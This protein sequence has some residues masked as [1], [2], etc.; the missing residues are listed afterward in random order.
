MSFFRSPL[1]ARA[2]F[3]ALLLTAAAVAPAHAQTDDDGIRLRLV[4]QPVWHD[5]KDDLD[6]VV[7][8]ENGSSV[9]LEGFSLQVRVFSLLTTRSDLE[10][11]L[12][13]DPSSL[14]SGLVPAEF[15]TTILPGRA[16]VVRLDQ[17][18][19]ALGALSADLGAGVYPLTVTL[20]DADGI[21]ALDSISTFL[22]FFPSEVDAPLQIVPV[23]AFAEVPAR[24]PAGAFEPHPSAGTWNLEAALG[25]R[26]WVP[27][28]LSALATKA[29]RGVRLGIAASPR[30]LEELADMANGYER[31]DD[32]GVSRVRESAGV[33]RT[34]GD[35]LDALGTLLRSGRAQPLLAP[36][37][38]PELPAIA[39]DLD[40]LQQQLSEGE[41]VL[42][43]ALDVTPGRG[44]IFPP[45]GRLD[46]SS[47]DDLH[48]LDAAASTFFSPESLE[49]P[50]ALDPSCPP[51]FVGATYTCPVKVTTFGGKSRGYV[52]DDRL[53]ERAVAMATGTGRIALQR[54]FAETAMIWAEQPAVE[55]R[56]VPLV[57]PASWHPPPRVANLFVRT[58]GRAPW[59]TTL[60]PRAGLHRG[61]G[62]GTRILE[63]PDRLSFLDH[64]PY[65]STLLGAEDALESFARIDPPVDM[66]EG[67]RRDLLVAQARSWGA[68]DE[69]LDRGLEFA[70][71]VHAQVDRQFEAITMEGRQ[72]ITLTSRTG[73]IPLVLKNDTGYDVTL[74]IE[75]FWTDL[76]LEIDPATVEQT[77]APGTSPL[78]VEATARASGAVPVEVRIRTPDGEEIDSRVITIRSTE[79]NEIALAITL[80]ALAFLVLFYVFRGMRR[81]AASRAV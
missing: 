69:M 68:D 46:T 80:G 77:F 22:L 31:R 29:G 71:A 32:E 53:Q 36:Y 79:Y 40:R 58:L 61:I 12:E 18:L 14:E 8:V 44:W 25:A 13:V 43:S 1:N 81:G 62:A 56:I 16:R 72:E 28:I 27:E 70:R 11:N 60:T 10:E 24:G 49:S 47:L 75:I 33:P 65:R 9:P 73:E 6:L 35:T 5:A 66:L 52:L 15:A 74:E 45:G 55:D 17:P 23:W 21:T 2:V 30:T 63:D 4:G 38:L 48:A 76:D 20:T 42:R 41:E 37:S 3:V 19:T 59:I 50:D 67:L 64:E 7:R 34:A 54:L 51:P 39:R 78:A 57:I 26:G